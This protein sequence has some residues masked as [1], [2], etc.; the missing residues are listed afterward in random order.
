MA[1]LMAVEIA[2]H[3]YEMGLGT[4]AFQ[5]RPDS[6]FQGFNSR[7]FKICNVFYNLDAFPGGDYA[8][9]ALV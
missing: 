1:V 7:I 4:I 6:A 9:L 3:L 8:L 2:G 5:Q